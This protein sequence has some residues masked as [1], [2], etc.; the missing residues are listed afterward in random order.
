MDV[1]DGP[2][3][4]STDSLETSLEISLLLRR[5]RTAAA[6][7]AVRPQNPQGPQT[8]SRIQPLALPK[9]DVATTTDPHWRWPKNKLSSAGN[10]PDVPNT[11]R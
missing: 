3:W 1:N 4:S 11:G 7:A 10:H 6:A 2:L 9:R 8:Y 5:C